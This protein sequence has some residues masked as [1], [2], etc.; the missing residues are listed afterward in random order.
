MLVGWW[1]LRSPWES[2]L[3]YVAVWF[4]NVCLHHSD[5]QSQPANIVSRLCWRKRWRI[6]D[7]TIRISQSER[8]KLW[9]VRLPCGSRAAGI[10]DVWE[11]MNNSRWN[12]VYTSG[13]QDDSEGSK[14]EGGGF[15]P[16]CLLPGGFLPV[17]GT[18]ESN[19][20]VNLSPLT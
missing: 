8:K 2:R 16:L 9:K 7:I 3:R 1:W 20:A 13:L 15:Y 18:C 14:A 17:Q 4:T 19:I 5:S 6:V 12:T 10:S 11:L